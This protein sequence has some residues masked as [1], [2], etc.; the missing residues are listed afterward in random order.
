MTYGRTA[1]SSAGQ[2]SPSSS[3]ANMPL[4]TQGDLIDGQPSS[5]DRTTSR[6]PRRRRTPRTSS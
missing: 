3:M 1:G 2:A 6:K 4:P 5:P